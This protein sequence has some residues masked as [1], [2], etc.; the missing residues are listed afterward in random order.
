MI[1][2][3]MRGLGVD[4]LNQANVYNA[5]LI[6]QAQ[7]ALEATAAA[8]ASAEQR[9]LTGILQAQLAQKK[10]EMLMRFYGTVQASTQ[11]KLFGLQDGARQQA[12]EASQK[13]M[14]EIAQESQGQPVD[15]RLN[16][17]T[18]HQIETGTAITKGTIAQMQA[19]DV[20]L[21]RAPTTHFGVPSQ[22]DLIRFDDSITGE[23]SELI[24]NERF[25]ALKDDGPLS[26]ESV[27]IKLENAFMYSRN[28]QRVV[29]LGAEVQ[30]LYGEDRVRD[31][32]THSR[33]G[34][35]KTKGGA[36]PEVVEL[37]IRMNQAVELQ[38]RMTRGKMEA[39]RGPAEQAIL[40]KRAG[41]PG[42]TT[43]MLNLL[44]SDDMFNILIPG[45]KIAAEAARVDIGKYTK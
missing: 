41:L 11:M 7:S 4:R 38:Q 36:E 14:L 26:K 45:A 17:L 1:F 13:K 30:V 5:L 6:S 40:A 12:Q 18:K 28:W 8:T 39:I 42:N 10:Q 2:D 43:A 9:H 24:P 31:S 25:M 22:A 15:E 16:R 33:F 21:G 3:R 20:D 29:E 23:M 35:W 32:L 27:R 44:F 19:G 34:G 37:S